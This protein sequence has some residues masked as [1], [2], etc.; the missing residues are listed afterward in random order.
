MIQVH[1]QRPLQRNHSLSCQL[2]IRWNNRVM[3]ASMSTSLTTEEIKYLKELVAAGERGRTIGALSRREGLKRLVEAGY[4]VS[5][6]IS[7]HAVHY[8]I[9]EKGRTAL[10]DVQWR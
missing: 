4:V 10:G 9:T 7:Y 5:R 3:L 6:P 2:L 8:M 1:L